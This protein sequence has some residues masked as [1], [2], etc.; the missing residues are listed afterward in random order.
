MVIQMAEMDNAVQS[1][2]IKQVKTTI[3][4]TVLVLTE[5]RGNKRDRRVELLFWVF[6]RDAFWVSNEVRESERGVVK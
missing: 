4:L 1:S 2:L 3:A 6:V 5:L